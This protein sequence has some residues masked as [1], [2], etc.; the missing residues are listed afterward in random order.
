[1]FSLLGIVIVLEVGPLIEN[2]DA[3]MWKVREAGRVALLV[4][5]KNANKFGRIDP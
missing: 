3:V 5:T 4:Q 1:L 2:G